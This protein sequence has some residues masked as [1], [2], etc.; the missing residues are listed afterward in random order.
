[1]AKVFFFWGGALSRFYYWTANLHK[2]NPCNDK[3]KQLDSK[4]RE[5]FA[6]KKEHDGA[7]LLKKNLKKM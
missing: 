2:V 5:I 4:V 3:R 6:D 7:G 1:M